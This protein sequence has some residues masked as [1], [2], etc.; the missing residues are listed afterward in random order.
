MSETT[1]SAVDPTPAVENMEQPVPPE[2]LEKINIF[3]EATKKMSKDELIRE[4]ANLGQTFNVD[5]VNEG[6]LRRHV[7]RQYQ[8][9]IL[10]EAGILNVPKSV[11]KNDKEHESDPNKTAPDKK[12]VG[13]TRMT[14]EGNYVLKLGED[15]NIG[16][17]GSVK[18]GI[19][20]R[21]KDKETFTFADF[22]KACIDAMLYDPAAKSFGVDT[23]FE[24]ID[25]A[26]GA[27]WSELKNKAKIIEPVP[28][29]EG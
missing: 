26:A 28:T 5:A 29:P 8:K 10:A 23:R 21:I 1:D 13:R 27:W 25:A 15:G 2:V 17:A 6:W 19:L 18:F 4:A 16:R 9:F 11:K 14:K 12:R 20:S 24:T 3:I 7:Q 22:H